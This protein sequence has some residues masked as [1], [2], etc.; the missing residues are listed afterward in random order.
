MAELLRDLCWDRRFVHDTSQQPHPDK[1][2]CEHH[3][4]SVAQERAKRM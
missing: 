2:R 4:F 1:H 3:H